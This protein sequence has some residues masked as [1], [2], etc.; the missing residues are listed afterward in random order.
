MEGKG[1]RE[2]RRLIL[3]KIRLQFNDRNERCEMKGVWRMF[4]QG[5]GCGEK[6][7]ENSVRNNVSYLVSHDL[8]AVAMVAMNWN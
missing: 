5:N 3:K 6:F 8:V 2:G 7:I 4:F 1:N